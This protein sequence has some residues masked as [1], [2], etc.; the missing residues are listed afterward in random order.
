[1]NIILIGM[2]G[3]GKSTVGIA[4]AKALGMTFCDTDAV[5]EAREGRKLQEIINARGDDAFRICEEQALASI[6]ADN[7]VIATGGSAVYSDLAMRH[8]KKSGPAVY[9]HVGAEEIARRLADFSKRG[10]TIRSG[11]T[12]M[13]LYEERRPLYERY[14]DITVSAEGDTAQDV[15]RRVLDALE[16]FKKA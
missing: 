8:L 14:A 5:I 6:E 12:I 13:D 10:I 4:L 2:P 11:M 1:M 15:V 3:C 16:N 9:L 7:T